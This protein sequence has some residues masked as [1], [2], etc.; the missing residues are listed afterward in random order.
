MDVDDLHSLANEEFLHAVDKFQAGSM[1]FEKWLRFRLWTRFLD[2]YRSQWRER[3][4]RRD[5]SIM[6][7]IPAGTGKS[8]S[9][10]LEDLSPDATH[11]ANLAI[12]MPEAVQKEAKSKGGTPQNYASSLRDDCRRRGWS[13]RRIRY[14]VNEI[15]EI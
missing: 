3:E 6:N 5:D 11:L 15:R 14:A 1:S 7:F 12:E 13:T 8:W 4:K 9:E 10:F 2:Y